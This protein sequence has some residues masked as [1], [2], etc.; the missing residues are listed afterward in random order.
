MRPILG[1]ASFPN[2]RAIKR[3]IYLPAIETREQKED[4]D[5]EVLTRYRMLTEDMMIQGKHRASPYKKAMGG[6]N[7]KSIPDIDWHNIVD[8]CLWV[9]AYTYDRNKA[10][11]II[12]FN[13]E[14]PDRKPMRVPKSVCP[15][16]NY[17]WKLI[18]FTSCTWYN[19]YGESKSNC[20]LDENRLT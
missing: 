1:N 8:H 3:P 9:A 5:N 19:K 6:C 2:P 16:P 15:L 13:N 10:E 14:N 20:S 11:N 17:F 12:K 4:W 18:Y 7:Q